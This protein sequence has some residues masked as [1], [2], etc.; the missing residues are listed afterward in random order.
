MREYIVGAI[1]VV[2]AAVPGAW[3]AWLTMSAAG[4]NGVTLA[5][6]ATGLAMLFSTALF[7]VLGRACEAVGILNKK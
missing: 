4:L 3:L 5:L 2:V 1:L 6:A 7:A